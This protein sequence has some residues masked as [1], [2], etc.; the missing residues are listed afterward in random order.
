MHCFVRGHSAVLAL[1]LVV[2]LTAIVWCAG[3]ARQAARGGAGS[4]PEVSGG[5]TPA[6][7]PPS[8]PPHTG[9]GAA[10]AEQPVPG[11]QE[12]Q[13]GGTSPAAP[14]SGQGQKAPPAPTNVGVKSFSGSGDGSTD[15]FTVSGYCWRLQ[16]Y[17]GTPTVSGN[18]GLLQ[19]QAQSTTDPVVF[20]ALPADSQ[21]DRQ[22][23]TDWYTPGGKRVCGPEDEPPLGE[24]TEGPSVT[25][26]LN[27]RSDNRDW[28]ITVE[29]ITS[30]PPTGSTGSAGSTG[31]GASPAQPGS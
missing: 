27:V 26:K 1:T 16:Y 10:A 23:S 3:C 20:P 25:Y 29:E 30:H 7:P 13:P 31:A 9:S 24:L 19:A 6:S 21:T 18:R 22:W 2:A 5:S 14:P 12:T 17:T 15:P 11:P 8:V 4:T 28:Q